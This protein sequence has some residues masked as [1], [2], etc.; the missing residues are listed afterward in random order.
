[1]DGPI[2]EICK[3]MI[4]PGEVEM[5]QINRNVACTEHTDKNVGPNYTIVFGRF[6]G[7]ELEIE[8]E[9]PHSLKKV[10]RKYDASKKH[11]VTKIHSGIR[12]SLTAFRK[13]DGSGPRNAILVVDSEQGRVSTPQEPCAE[14]EPPILGDEPV[15]VEVPSDCESNDQNGILF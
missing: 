15:P 11:R 2:V 4:P 14:E 3:K 8:G 12:V 5:V 10:W 9:R 6:E 7:G 1:M 13:V